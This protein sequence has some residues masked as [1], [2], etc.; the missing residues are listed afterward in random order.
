MSVVLLAGAV[1]YG[2]EMKMHSTTNIAMIATL[3]H[4]L[5]NGS[6]VLKNIVRDT[7]AFETFFLI[8]I[9]IILS[10]LR[11]LSWKLIMTPIADHTYLI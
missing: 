5:M 7:V 6:Q 9:V 11:F 3:I 10:Y 2:L 4:L 1:A 8:N